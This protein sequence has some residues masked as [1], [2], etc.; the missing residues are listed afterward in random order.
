M[1]RIGAGIIGLGIGEQHVAGFH[2]LPGCD[3]VVLC[4]LSQEKLDR[5]AAG[6]PGVRRTTCWRELIDDLR[7]DV[8]SVASFDDMHVEQTVAALEAGK[9]VFVEKPLCRSA[10]ELRR[11]KSAFAQR[12]HLALG[13]NLVLR[14]APVY[15]WLR[16]A[17]AAGD[18]GEIYAIDGD[19]L[20]GRLHKITEGW[21]KDID[22]YSVIQGGGI[23]LVDLMLWLSGQKPRHVTACGN[24]ICTRDTAFRFHDFAAATFVFES[25][26]IGRIT[27]NFGCVHRHQHVLRVFGTRATFILDDQGPRLHTSR[28]PSEPPQILEF[29]TLPA[30]KWELIPPFVEQIVRGGDAAAM[31]QREFDTISVCLAADSAMA[32]GTMI[33]IDYE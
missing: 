8:V 3:V 5:V 13:S 7:V 2:S 30:A 23:H 19:Y 14:A 33:E 26:M 20:F 29:A 10:D 11:I 31:A 24:R 17:I 22:Q 18:F 21:R 6:Y 27:A 25:G 32:T 15:R 16:D 9:H 28:A 12:A 1:N 4:D